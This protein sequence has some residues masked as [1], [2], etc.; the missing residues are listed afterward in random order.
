MNFHGLKLFWF[1][2]GTRYSNPNPILVRFGPSDVH[3]QFELQ[4]SNN[5]LVDAPTELNI[6][7]SIPDNA[8]L[9]GIMLGAQQSAVITLVDNG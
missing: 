6:M 1:S 2:V 5:T 9:L 8:S 4:F 7:L 3:Q